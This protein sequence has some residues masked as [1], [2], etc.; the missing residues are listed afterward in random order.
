MNNYE[1][2]SEKDITDELLDYLSAEVEALAQLED[3]QIEGYMDREVL[4]PEMDYLFKSDELAK[5][6]ADDAGGSEN[7][8][9]TLAGIYEL[10]A[11][12]KFAA[13]IGFWKNLKRKIRRIFC[14]V[15]DAI[16]NIEEIT[17][18][19]IIE[20]VLA[21]VLASIGLIVKAAILPV[22]IGIIAYF[23]KK[24]YGNVCSV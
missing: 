2:K 5:F 8:N 22:I 20:L 23:I 10:K 7:E 24:G 12:R 11:T 3:S 19:K 6:L 21:A 1:L 9:L 4:N 18:K 16:E 17:L 13:R 15:I 14:S